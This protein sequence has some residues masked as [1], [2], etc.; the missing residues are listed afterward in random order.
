VT[1][2]VAQPSNADNH[3]GAGKQIREDDPLDLLER[4]GE[5]LRQRRQRNICDADAE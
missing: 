2:D 3:D 4:G 5:R 1:H